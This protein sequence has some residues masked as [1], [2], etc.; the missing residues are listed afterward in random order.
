MNLTDPDRQVDMITGQ[1]A[2]VAL[3]DTSQ[4]EPDFLVGGA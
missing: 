1:Y 4:R 3:D 2:R